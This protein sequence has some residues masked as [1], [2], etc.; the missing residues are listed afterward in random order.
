LGLRD[1]LRSDTFSY[2]NVMQQRANLLV[3][4]YVSVALQGLAT[5]L[6]PFLIPFGIHSKLL[7]LQGFSSHRKFANFGAVAVEAA[8]PFVLLTPV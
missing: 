3:R 6:L 4:F 1:V 7:I 5:L 2:R 8:V